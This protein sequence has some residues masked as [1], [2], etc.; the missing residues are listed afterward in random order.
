M[1]QEYALQSRTRASQGNPCNDHRIP[2]MR[3]GF[4]VTKT[5]ISLWELTYGEFPVSLTWFGFAVCVCFTATRWWIYPSKK[6][7]KK[8]ENLVW[9]LCN[10]SPPDTNKKSL[11][12][13]PLLRGFLSGRYMI[14]WCLP[15]IKDAWLLLRAQIQIAILKRKSCNNSHSRLGHYFCSN[16]YRSAPRGPQG[17]FLDLFEYSS[18]WGQY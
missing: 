4:S 6:K 10:Y 2:A 1:H 9:K 11:M 17:C 15:R 13:T 18:I 3:T 8:Q 12:D 16:L 5:R 7:Q 14:S